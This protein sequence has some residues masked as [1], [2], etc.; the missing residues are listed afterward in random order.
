MKSTTVNF[1]QRPLDTNKLIQF[2]TT[3]EMWDRQ[4]RGRDFDNEWPEAYQY[5]ITLIR[6]GEFD[7]PALNS[8]EMIGKPRER[9][10]ILRENPNHNLKPEDWHAW[11]NGWIEGIFD[12]LG[13]ILGINE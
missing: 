10:D 3:P 4:E 5:L 13:K 8:T 6:N 7:L 9:F 1:G 11:Y 12:L 2:L